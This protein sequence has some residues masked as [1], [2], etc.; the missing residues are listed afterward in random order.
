MV[1]N[2]STLKMEVVYRFETLS[3]AYHT[4]P[5]QPRIESKLYLL[6]VL[7]SHTTA[8]LSCIV[9]VIMYLASS[10]MGTGG[11]FLWSKAAGACS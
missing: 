9:I 8:L 4:T 3:S 2:V 6:E 1:I 7:E 11:S 5:R 10:S